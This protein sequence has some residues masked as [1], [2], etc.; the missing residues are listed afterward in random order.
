VRISGAQAR[1]VAAISEEF[2]QMDSR[3]KDIAGFYG[4]LKAHDLLLRH[5]AWECQRRDPQF[6]ERLRKA[7]DTAL[8]ALRAETY[9]SDLDPFALE[10]DV[11]MR[12]TVR[13]ILET[14]ETATADVQKGLAAANVKPQTL[15]RRFLNWLERGW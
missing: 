5:I 6:A 3:Q 8:G 11:K 7:L 9:P 1:P 13:E 4:K 12:E 2:S 15:R 14:I 10:I